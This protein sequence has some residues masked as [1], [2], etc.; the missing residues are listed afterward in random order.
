ME[1]NMK[2]KRSFKRYND[3]TFAPTKRDPNAPRII[4]LCVKLFVKNKNKPLYV[5]DIYENLKTKYNWK[6]SSKLPTQTIAS[7]LLT[8]YKFKKVG[9][10]TFVL[11]DEF[12]N[13]RIN[14]M[15]LSKLSIFA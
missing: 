14:R 3:G 6:T 10:N 1:K 9:R 13:N 8:N 5:K 4:D 2:D 7:R 12:Y 11:N 15:K